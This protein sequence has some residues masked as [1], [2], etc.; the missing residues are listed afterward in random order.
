MKKILVI[1]SAAV[2][3]VIP[4]ERFPERGGEVSPKTENLS[5]LGPAFELCSCLC[6]F[7][8][9]VIPYLPVGSGVYG[10]YIRGEMNRHGFRS[11]IPQVREMNGCRYLFVEPDGKST[12]VNIRGAEYS[13]YPEWFESLEQ[14]A[15]EI[16]SVYL[17]GQE[18][19]EP[20]GELILGFLELHPKMKVYFQPAG[21]ILK[22]SASRMERLFLRNPVIA[23]SREE[24]LAY[25]GEETPE[26]AGLLMASWS[27]GTVLTDLG[28]EN[29]L[30]TE[31]SE[32][33]GEISQVSVPCCPAEGNT[34]PGKVE[35]SCF[36]SY[37]ALRKTGKTAREASCL[38]ARMEAAISPESPEILQSGLGQKCMGTEE[39]LKKEGTP[40]EA[41]IEAE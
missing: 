37:I 4:V 32:E 2:D 3:I 29:G 23:L 28:K 35:E 36:A 24:V 19:V 16:D 34:E 12:C 13:F 8:L 33:N 27:G 14:R 30:L 5:V 9:P 26:A 31:V 7:G 22:I 25:T 38:A 15:W 39:E 40:K 41:H 11:A 17:T 1:G 21:Q 20:T 6:R 10:D 18:F